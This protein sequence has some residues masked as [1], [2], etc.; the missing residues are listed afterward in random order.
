MLGFRP[1]RTTLHEKYDYPGVQG[2]QAS[3]SA[4]VSDSPGVVTAVEA[5]PGAVVGAGT[6]IVRVAIDGPRD[7]VFAVPEDKVAGLR[8]LQGRP[9][10]VQLRLWAQEGATTPATVREIAAA[11][12]AATRTFL[13]KADVGRAAVALGQTATSVVAIPAVTGIIR[14][15]LTAVT[16]EQ[17]RSAVWIVE[18]GTMTVRPQPI[19]VAGADANDVV[20]AAGVWPGQRVVTA[21]V[22]ALT[23]GQKVR[24]YGA[25][26]PGPATAGASAA[27]R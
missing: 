24:L 19:E 26:G 2:N 8:A 18:P 4:L 14:L 1:K 6:P 21:G 11:A 16:H 23:P 20:V 5:E 10:G 15:P 7:A 13:V 22:H 27:A 17:G 3:Y 12:D 25:P 9:G